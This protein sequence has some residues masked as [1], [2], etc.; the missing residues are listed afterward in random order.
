MNT[1]NP[2]LCLERG[3]FVCLLLHKVALLKYEG[4]ILGMVFVEGKTLGNPVV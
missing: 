4:E 3:S 1:Q 2:P